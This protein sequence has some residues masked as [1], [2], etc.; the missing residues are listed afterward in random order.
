MENIYGPQLPKEYQR[1]T[2]DTTHRPLHYL[3]NIY[4]PRLPKEYRKATQ[5]N[6]SPITLS[7][8]NENLLVK[9]ELKKEIS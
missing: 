6:P 2:Q 7:Q 9:K 8:N 4:F 1:A 5:H 3:E